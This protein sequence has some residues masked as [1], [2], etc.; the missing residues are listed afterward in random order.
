MPQPNGARARCILAACLLLVPLTAQA[1]STPIQA[2]S[3]TPS[4]TRTRTPTQTA[5]PTATS[6]ATSTPIPL[7]AD[8]NCDGRASAADFSAIVIVSGDDSR[9]P[10]CADADPFR[11]RPVGD[12]DFLPLLHD[13][14]DTFA[15]PFT[16]T[17]TRS[18]TVTPTGRGTLTHTRTAMP[19]TTPTRT[20]SRTATPTRSPTD[21][22]TETPTPVPTRTLTQT[23]TRTPTATRTPTPTATPTGLAFQL[24]G[25]WA[26]DWTSQICYLNGVPFDALRDTTY[27]V[28]AI[29]GRLDVEIVDGVRL[30]RGLPIDATGGV[31]TT[32]RIFDQ[33][34]CLVTGVRQEYVFDY[35]FTLRTNGTGSARAHWTYGFNTNC[36]VCEVTDTATLRRVAGPGG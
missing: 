19:T 25:D 8:A 16:P 24:S 4:P 20:A 18:P 36:A 13:I 30:G 11:G 21:T 12:P 28:T 33:R 17:P 2:P 7:V 1:Q 5:T 32:Y 14:F 34:T 15:A 26:A 29:D 6:T 23:L 10:G 9:F 3:L 27:R 31:Q 22:P 35:T